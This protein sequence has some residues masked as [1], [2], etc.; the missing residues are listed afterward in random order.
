VGRR[1][2][3][4]SSAAQAGQKSQA[5]VATDKMTKEKRRSSGPLSWKVASRPGVR[6]VVPAFQ[7]GQPFRSTRFGSYRRLCGPASR[8]RICT[9]HM[10]IA[11]IGWGSLIWCPGSLRIK[12]RWRP[13][14]PALPIEFARISRD[15]RLTLVIHPGSPELRTYWAISEFPTLIE[16]RENLTTREGADLKDIHSATAQDPKEAATSEAAARITVWLKN[17]ED[18]QAAI[19][20]GLSSNWNHRRGR[21][22]TPEDAAEYLRELE[23]A[24][25]QATA[26]YERARE[27]MRN[28]P[29]QTQTRVRKMMQRKKGWEDAALPA[30]LFETGIGRANS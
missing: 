14:G 5:I 10:Q 9:T 13:D 6:R 4:R 12:T 25:D 7:A 28:A 20:T 29:P 18:L 22:F 3:S 15:G 24:K 19:W 26:A 30:V 27:Y 1:V 8:H 16:A 11:V 17:Q 2:F 23:E 21:P